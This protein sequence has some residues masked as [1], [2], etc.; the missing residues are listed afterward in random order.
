MDLLVNGVRS[1]VDTDPERPLLWVLRNELD[2]TGAPTLHVHALGYAP[3]TP[4]ESFFIV[5]NES[6][7][8]VLG[9]F[10]AKFAGV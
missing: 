1:R 5:N 6:T 4:G 2:L 8:P 7:D 10:A 9:N 3:A